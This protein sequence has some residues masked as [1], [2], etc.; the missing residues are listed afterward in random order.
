MNQAISTDVL[1]VGLGPAGA[2]AAQACAKAGFR[3]IAVDRKYQAGVPV[4]CAEFVP[5]MLSA[6]VN[7]VNYAKCQHIKSM[8]TFIENAPLERKENFPGVMVDRAKFDQQLVAGASRAGAECRFRTT[9]SKLDLDGT[10]HLSTG[11]Q[12]KP[13]VLIGA[14]GPRSRIGD[15]IDSKNSEVVVSR[16]LTVALIGAHSATDIFLSTDYRGGYGWLFPRGD[17]ANLGIGVTSNSLEMLKPLLNDLHKSIIAVKRVGQDVLS[18]TGGIIPVGGMI[19]PH[20]QLG[21][22]LVLLCGD[23]AGLTNPITGAGISSAILSGIL[24][25]D[26]AKNWLEG[27]TGSDENYAEELHELFGAASARAVDRRHKLLSC[28]KSG[29]SPTKSDL[30]SAWVAYP[31]YWTA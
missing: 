4:Q 6:T 27:D 20:G 29:S 7:A 3:V 25:G 2:S 8:H 9:V 22:V 30:R 11:E 21:A 10:V 23:A 19:K 1:I 24:A 15:A 26:A 28:Y 13:I 31:E 17:I 18:I 14:D 5:A 12:I 16:Q